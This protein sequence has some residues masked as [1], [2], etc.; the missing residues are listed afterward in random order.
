MA[1][2]QRKSR[3]SIGEYL[4]EEPYKFDFHQAL[5]ILDAL[6]PKGVP[7]GEGV[8]PERESVQLRSRVFLGS[9]PSQLQQ[10]LPGHRLDPP[11]LEVNFMGIAGE[12]GPLPA[13]YAEMLLERKAKKDHAMDDFLQIFNHRLLSM[14]ARNGRKHWP[15]L[16]NGRIEDNPFADTLLS[17]SGMFFLKDSPLKT[18]ENRSFLPYTGMLWDQRCSARSLQDMIRNFLQVPAAVKS[19]IGKW[20]H[21]PG[22]AQTRIHSV[23]EKGQNH[24]LGE[25]ATLGDRYW[26]QA[27][28]ILVELDLEKFERWESLLPGQIAWSRVMTL[29]RSAVPSQIQVQVKLTL[30]QKQFKPTRL[31]QQSP[32]GWGSFL[33]SPKKTKESFGISGEFCQNLELY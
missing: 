26:D 8:L 31:D 1:S 7:V 11:K 3:P 21:I 18:I 16:H 13:V 28:E 5:K 2:P 10:L 12:S 33:G 19:F 24:R 22:N 6:N 20:H 23:Y 14:V 29:I 30:S 32:L 15:A 25:T 27:A 17:L 9:S 4:F